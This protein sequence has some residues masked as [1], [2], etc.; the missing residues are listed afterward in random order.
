MSGNITLYRIN[1]IKKIGIERVEWLEGP[2][3]PAKWTIEELQ[4]IIS[5]Y[6][7]KLKLLKTLWAS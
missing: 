1:L 5:T 4:G 2:H 7:Q 3:P 6:K